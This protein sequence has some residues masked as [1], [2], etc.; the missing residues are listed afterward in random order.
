LAVAE[1]GAA[2]V[3]LGNGNGTFQAATEYGTNYQDNAIASGDFNGD[4]K[5]DLAL[6]FGST[7]VSQVFYDT[8]L[9]G[10]EEPCCDGFGSYNY[11]ESYPIYAITYQVDVSAGVTFLEGRGD[12]TFGPATDVTTLSYSYQSDWLN[13]SEDYV[14]ALALG[15][16]DGNSSL[17]VAAGD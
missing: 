7:T 8:S 2:A 1:S 4:G 10:G 9:S 3:L 16:F 15:H 5:P 6:G 14:S 12:G 17:D 11:G 13:S